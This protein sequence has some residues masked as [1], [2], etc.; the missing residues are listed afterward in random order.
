MYSKNNINF[1]S[2]IMWCFM[3]IFENKNKVKV[4]FIINEN[5]ILFKLQPALPLGDN[6]I[7]RKCGLATQNRDYIF[8]KRVFET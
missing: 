2:I 4:K 3:N 8:L 5:S 6:S 7:Y 1:K